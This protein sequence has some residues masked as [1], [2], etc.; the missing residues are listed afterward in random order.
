MTGEKFCTELGQ[1]L[2]GVKPYDT[3]FRVVWPDSTVHWL[4]GKGKV[5]RD[6]AGNPVRM[7]GAD[8]DITSRRL[9]EEALRASEEQL[10]ALAGSLFT[11]QEE[12]RRRM[13]RELHDDFNQR[14]AMLVN[15]VVTLE[16]GLC[17]GTALQQPIESLRG[18]LEELSDDLRDTA[19]R[20]HSSALEHLGLVAALESYCA[21]FLKL[22]PIGL[23]F[24]RRSVP[25]FIPGDIALCLYRVA[26]ECLHNIAKHSGATQATVT[27]EGSKRRIRLAICDNGKGFVSGLTGNGL[28]LVGIRERVRLVGGTVSIDPGPG[29]GARIEAEVALE[30]KTK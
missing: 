11:A 22:Y 27:L 1:A 23:E 8:M 14:M 19:H 10:Q 9:T 24:V 5:L 28:G 29:R 13:A 30:G 18:K 16:N 20:L 12:E 2:E 17:R 15:E 7:F 26:Q 3:E 25:S 21:D 4:I 6:P